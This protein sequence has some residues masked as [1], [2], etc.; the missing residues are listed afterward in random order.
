MHIRA[1]QVHK[2]GL[3][4]TNLVISS[5]DASP[6]VTDRTHDISSSTIVIKKGPKGR[7][8]LTITIRILITLVLKG[9]DVTG[10]F[11]ETKRVIEPIL[12]ITSILFTGA[13]TIGAEN[14]AK[15]IIRRAHGY[16]PWIRVQIIGRVKHRGAVTIAITFVRTRVTWILEWVRGLKNTQ[17]NKKRRNEKK[18][19]KN[20]WH[21]RGSEF[22]YDTRQKNEFLNSRESKYEIRVLRIAACVRKILYTVT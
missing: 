3:P 17:R 11:I 21:L 7:G 2:I 15:T 18:G 6:S 20:P 10:I 12:E 19:F 5:Y 8:L 13:P 14:V 4:N 9:A 22:T 16:T 1:I